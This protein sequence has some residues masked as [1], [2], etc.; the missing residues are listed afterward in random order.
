MVQT[1]SFVK[2][3]SRHFVATLTTN[4]FH[5]GQEFVTIEI[6]LK[7]VSEKKR[8]FL[9]L[10]VHPSRWKVHLRKRVVNI[11]CGLYAEMG[12]GLRVDG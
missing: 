4:I 10:V 5:N 1:F 12:S 3:I 2:L 7:V 9:K 11:P 8:V 6:C